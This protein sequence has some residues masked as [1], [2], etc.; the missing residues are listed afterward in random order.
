LAYG[1]E[2]AQFLIEYEPHQGL[3]L[4]DISALLC[5]LLLLLLLPRPLCHQ[6][7]GARCVAEKVLLSMR[8][9]MSQIVHKLRQY[10]RQP[11]RPHLERT[12]NGKEKRGE[13]KKTGGR[14]SAAAAVENRDASRLLWSSRTHPAAANQ[15]KPSNPIQL[16]RQTP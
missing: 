2:F 16:L 14:Q 3:S 7:R 10:P 12:G 15:N 4:H 5:L 8:L 6:E 9:R 13:G 11:R 1:Q